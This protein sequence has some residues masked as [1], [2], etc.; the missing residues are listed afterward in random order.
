MTEPYSGESTS[1]GD[2]LCTAAD[3]EEGPARYPFRIKSLK[4]EAV[5]M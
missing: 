1:Q 4:Q 5:H 3:D 2:Y